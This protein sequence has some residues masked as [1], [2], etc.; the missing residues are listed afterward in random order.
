MQT[1]ALVNGGQDAES[2][3]GSEAENEAEG[4]GENDDVSANSDV[5]AIVVNEPEDEDRTPDPHTE[6]LLKVSLGFSIQEADPQSRPVVITIF[7]RGIRPSVRPLFKISQN[8]TTF[9]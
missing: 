6:D 5:P 2:N 8:K 1:S 7:A 9:K 4:L 3:S